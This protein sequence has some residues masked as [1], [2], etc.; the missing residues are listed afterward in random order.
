MN[1]NN[2]KNDTDMFPVMTL[3]KA[4]QFPIIEDK[5]TQTDLP[6]DKEAQ[7]DYFDDKNL[8]SEGF[9]NSFK[10]HMTNRAEAEAQASLFK[11]IGGDYGDDGN[12]DYGDDDDEHFLLTMMN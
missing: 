5:E 2:N 7:T 4:T 3:N 12:D 9:S 8:I 1:L 10:S 6:N 11:P